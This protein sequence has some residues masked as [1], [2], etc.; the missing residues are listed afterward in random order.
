MTKKAMTL[1][2]AIDKELIIV[3]FDGKDK[4]PETEVKVYA[5][6]Y[7]VDQRKKSKVPFYEALQLG[8]INE[9]TGNY[10]NNKT[11]EEVYVV[12]AIQKGFLKGR[13]IRQEESKSLDVDAENKEVEEKITKIKR[14]LL[15]SLCAISAMKR[16]VA[17]HERGGD[18]GYE[19]VRERG[20][21]DRGHERVR[22][23]GASDREYERTR[24]RGA[25]RGGL[26]ANE[27]GYERVR[28]RGSTDR[29]GERVRRTRKREV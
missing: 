4:K 26:V 6:N 19:R 9:E 24:E 7:V 29:G 22:E 25:E 10:M 23:R 28:E 17:A 2:E 1:D 3:T 5:I 16:A 14:R 11:R 12:D 15:K 21:S 8:L 27:K 20:S 18:R 13:E